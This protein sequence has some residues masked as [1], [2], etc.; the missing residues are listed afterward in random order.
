M[1]TPTWTTN[2]LRAASTGWTAGV[3]QARTMSRV[4]R[5]LTCRHRVGSKDVGTEM[6]TGTVASP[7][8]QRLSK[9]ERGQQ[10]SG[11]SSSDTLEGLAA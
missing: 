1:S 9:G 10:G 3:A 6:G 7:L 5:T 2:W 11:Q 8:R 4:A